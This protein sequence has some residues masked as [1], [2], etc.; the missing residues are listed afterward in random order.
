MSSK[1]QF[2]KNLNNVKLLV[3]ILFITILTVT[4]IKSRIIPHS[5]LFIWMLFGFGVYIIQIYKTKTFKPLLNGVLGIAVSIILFLIA[6]IGFIIYGSDDLLG[7]GDVKLVF[8]LGFIIG[9]RITLYTTLL[10]TISGLLIYFV[11]NYIAHYNS[12]SLPLVPF[13]LCSYCVVIALEMHNE[14]KKKSILQSSTID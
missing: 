13:I 3:N 8:V 10:S 7:M 5:V 14:Y 12:G 9:F 11:F 1:T 6:A 4:D 2:E